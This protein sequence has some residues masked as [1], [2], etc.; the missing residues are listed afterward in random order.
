M[1]DTKIVPC[2]CICAKECQAVFSSVTVDF[3]QQ[4]G[5]RCAQV[6][7]RA[8]VVFAVELWRTRTSNYPPNGY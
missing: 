3:L 6:E 8:F 1:T 5:L 2:K 7:L 4:L